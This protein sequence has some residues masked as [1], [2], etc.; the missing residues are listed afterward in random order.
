MRT[1]FDS[2]KLN[3]AQQLAESSRALSNL[4]YPIDALE[5]AREESGRFPIQINGMRLGPLQLLETRMFTAH[6]SSVLS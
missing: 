1:Y 6:P 3:E 2:F 5:I 4:F